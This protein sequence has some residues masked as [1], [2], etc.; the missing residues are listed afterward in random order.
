MRITTIVLLALVSG[1]PLG[2][3]DPAAM[4]DID[5][6]F[7]LADVRGMLEFLPAR[8]SEMTAA[9]V[10]Q[11]PND[12]RRQMEP[13][14]KEV[15]L[16]FFDPD[17]FYRQLRTYFVNHH[18]AA[19]LT[20]FLALERTP[21]YRTMHRLEQSAETPAAQ[22]MRRRFEAGLKS[23]PPSPTRVNLL[24]RLDE[25]RNTTTMQVRIVTG[26]VMAMA[27]GVGV[28]PPPDRQA[29]LKALTAKVQPVL[30]NG[31]LLSNLFTF[32]NTEEA[33]IEDY[34]AALQQKDV[35]W[36]NNN[37]QAAMVAVAAERATR[38]GEDIKAKVEKLQAK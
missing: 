12:Q 30:A 29:Q 36:F 3:Q 18:D 16:K 6:A 27:T 33:D 8:I 21:V 20:T 7:Q 14:I 17:A 19:H 5:E 26:I 11:M 38:A 1:I 10:A 13:L 4:A 23:D 2:A 34:I 9:A 25:A 15:S 24:V 35:V 28:P 22:A 31:V 37:L 32:R